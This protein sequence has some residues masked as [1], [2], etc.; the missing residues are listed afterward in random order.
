MG[1][2]RIKCHHIL[3]SPGRRMGYCLFP[4]AGQN[5]QGTWLCDFHLR[6]FNR[7]QAD[8]CQASGS[9]IKCGYRCGRIA[10]GQ[11]DDTRWLC[12][13]HLAKTQKESRD[14]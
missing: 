9:E 2:M 14:D 13:E 11:D 5:I 3:S 6:Q 10:Q 4:T 7:M 8:R 1:T 12:A